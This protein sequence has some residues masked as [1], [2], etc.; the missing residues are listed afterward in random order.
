MG[1]LVKVCLPGERCWAK[2]IK[3]LPDGCWVGQVM[4]HLV[5]TDPVL[6]RKIAEEW[7]QDELPQL[8]DWREGDLII[9]KRQNYDGLWVWE[10]IKGQTRFKQEHG[11]GEVH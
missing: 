9:F 7:G 10:P 8:H 5:A 3:R 11:Y 6:R 1:D 2:V 4:N